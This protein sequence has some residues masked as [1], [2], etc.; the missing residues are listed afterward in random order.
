MQTNAGIKRK[1]GTSASPEH[2]APPPKAQQRLGQVPDQPPVVHESPHAFD[3]PPFD[4]TQPSPDFS[5]YTS[6]KG[7]ISI[8][9]WILPHS[10]DGSTAC[11]SPVTKPD[12]LDTQ[13]FETDAISDQSA[14]E[15]SLDDPT[16]NAPDTTSSTTA[17]RCRSSLFLSG[18]TNQYRGNQRSHCKAA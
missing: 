7:D 14:S 16:F 15:P 5:N 1:A 13:S 8:G 17:P 6:P 9:S 2:L 3:I 12:A 11:A 18:R 4:P 10:L